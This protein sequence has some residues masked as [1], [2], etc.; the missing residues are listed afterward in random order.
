M[1]GQLRVTQERVAAEL[2]PHLAAG[3][4]RHQ[5]DQGG[6]DAHDPQNGAEGGVHRLIVAARTTFPERRECKY[7]LSW[8]LVD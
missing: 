7:P 2:L 4:E 5:R 3:G 6:G 8:T 1:A